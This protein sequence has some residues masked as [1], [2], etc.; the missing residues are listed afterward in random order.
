MNVTYHISPEPRSFTFMNPYHHISKTFPYSSQVIPSCSQTNRNTDPS[1]TTVPDRQHRTLPPSGIMTLSIR[2]GSPHRRPSR[3]VYAQLYVM[4]YVPGS[5]AWRIDLVALIP[6]R[7]SVW[8]QVFSAASGYPQHDRTGHM[9]AGM[10]HAR[11]TISTPTGKLGDDGVQVSADAPSADA[12]VQHLQHHL[13]HHC[14]AFQSGVQTKL[15][16]MVFYRYRAHPSNVRA[17]SPKRVTDSDSGQSYASCRSSK[18][19]RSGRTEYE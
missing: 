12:T 4:Y 2:F 19:R 3:V 5:W 1:Q 10:S 6:S 13:Y 18:R 14:L 17:R 8:L 7:Y 16:R 11:P 15:K 9:D